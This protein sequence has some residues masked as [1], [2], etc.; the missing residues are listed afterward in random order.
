MLA[1]GF[2]AASPTDKNKFRNQRARE[3]AGDSNGS[4][5]EPGAVAID[6]L[7]RRRDLAGAFLLK[8]KW[9]TRRLVRV[10]LSWRRDRLTAIGRRRS[11]TAK[12]KCSNIAKKKYW[13]AASARL[14]QR[15]KINSEIRE[16]ESQREMLWRQIGERI[17]NGLNW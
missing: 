17:R 12:K 13:R 5:F 9:P 14:R 2:G 4:R 1:R 11:D 6:P 3:S 15:T 10:A 8:R 7:A 16:R